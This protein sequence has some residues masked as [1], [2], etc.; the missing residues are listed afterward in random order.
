MV[1]PLYVVSDVFAIVANPPATDP[2]GPSTLM[3][4]DAR[5]PSAPKLYPMQTQ[6]GLGDVASAIVSSTTG[7]LLVPNVNGLMIYSIQTP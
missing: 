2:T 5:T 1:Q 4:V 7:Y 3:I 6:F